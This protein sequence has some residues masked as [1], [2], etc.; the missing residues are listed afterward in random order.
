MNV[1][2]YYFVTIL[3]CRIIRISILT[4]YILLLVLFDLYKICLRCLAH[5][6]I[7]VPPEKARVS[8]GRPDNQSVFLVKFQPTISGFQ[9]AMRVH[10]HFS[11]RNQ[12]K[13]ELQLMRDSKGKKAASTE[14][15]EELLYAHIGVVE[16]LAL[17]DDGTKKRCK[18]RSMKE[19][20][21]NADA[22][23]NLEP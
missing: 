9:E 22:T 12:G 23:L 7:G 5:P 2:V 3:W 8:H 17:L 6:D 1:F 4:L 13:E 20:E 16:D 19:I 10:T 11:S 14:S 21:A 15:L 18:V